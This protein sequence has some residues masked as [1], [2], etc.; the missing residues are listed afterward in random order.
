MKSVFRAELYKVGHSWLLLCMVVLYFGIGFFYGFYGVDGFHMYKGLELFGLLPFAW[1]AYCFATVIVTGLFIGGDFTRGTIKNAL[2]AGVARRDYFWVR[3]A[4][5]MLLTTLSFALGQG[6]Y[7]IIHM[8]HPW[9]NSEQEITLLTSKLI[10]YSAV[11][12]LQL[13][14][15]VALMN[16]VCYF[17]KKQLAA[18]VTGM[19][20]VYME[21]I[22]RQMAE[23]NDME[24]ILQVVQY[25]PARV[26]YRMFEFAVYDQVFTMGFLKYGISAA[27]VIAVS[28]IVGY[29][30]F[31][32]YL[33]EY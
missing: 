29:V 12:L 15:Y 27:V 31:A 1:L 28:S 2:A 6:A 10:V 30:K 18:M 13:L 4:L 26:L 9:G 7:I 16:A 24:R 20:L 22:I 23:M 32:K 19:V 11:A 17:V 5:Q 3:L 25:M 14:A 33:G 8:V 21:A